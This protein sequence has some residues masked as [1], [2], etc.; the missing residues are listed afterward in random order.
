MIS[1]RVPAVRANRAVAAR[2]ALILRGGVA[3]SPPQRGGRLTRSSIFVTP[4]GGCSWTQLPKARSREAHLAV[5]YALARAASA[6]ELRGG[7]D[8]VMHRVIAYGSRRGTPSRGV[9]ASM[10]DSSEALHAMGTWRS[11]QAD[12]DRRVQLGQWCA[13]RHATLTRRAQLGEQDAA[14]LGTERA[15]LRTWASLIVAD[16][17]RA[18]R[19]H[20]PDVRSHH[21]GPVEQ[22]P[23]CSAATETAASHA[24]AT[25]GALQ[26]GLAG[27]RRAEH[28]R[29]AGRSQP[30]ST[31]VLLLLDSW[32]TE[33]LE[34]ARLR[35]RRW[36][37][38]AEGAR[39]KSSLCQRWLTTE[40]SPRCPPR[41]MQ[42]DR[43]P[44]ARWQHR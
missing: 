28:L 5:V 18:R 31:S 24:E 6:Q 36:R 7:D 20:G 30:R 22:H 42:R 41:G 19:L 10:P 44:H 23:L 33:V 13:R 11:M 34:K 2:G 39:C 35:A 27:M 12:L 4:I 37:G 3:R 40:A 21:L 15:Q 17:S 43:T 38:A 32:N 16:A 25:V 8:G 29:R 9:N 1:A 26:S 14:Q